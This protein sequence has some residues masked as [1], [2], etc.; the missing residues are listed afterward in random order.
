M[1]ADAASTGA[2]EAKKATFHMYDLTTTF[3]KYLDPHM[4]IM[5]ID[6]ILSKNVCSLFVLFCFFSLRLFCLLLLLSFSLC[7]L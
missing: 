5:M 2:E 3:M 7:L 4:S 1:S 6:F